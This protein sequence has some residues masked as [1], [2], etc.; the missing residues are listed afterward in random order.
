MKPILSVIVGATCL[1]VVD[2][3]LAETLTVA[4]CVTATP[5]TSALTGK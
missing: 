2:S 1:F 3:A 4:V 5:A